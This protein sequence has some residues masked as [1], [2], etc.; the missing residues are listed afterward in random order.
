M[1]LQLHVIK[2]MLKAIT[3]KYIFSFDLFKNCYALRLI[4]SAN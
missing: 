2:T 4:Q 3:K 1:C